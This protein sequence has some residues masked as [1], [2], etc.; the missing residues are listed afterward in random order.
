MA[1]NQVLA[2]LLI[3]CVFLSAAKHWRKVLLVFVAAGM[4]ALCVGIFTVVG[5]IHNNVEAPASHTNHPDMVAE[6]STT[7]PR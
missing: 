7:Q 3:F 1:G 6:P 4:T 2:M 5:T